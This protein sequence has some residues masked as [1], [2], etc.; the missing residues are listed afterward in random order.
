MFYNIKN[1]MVFI[2]RIAILFLFILIISCNQN[3]NKPNP[4]IPPRFVYE[5]K[6]VKEGELYFLNK[7]DTLKK[8]NI[9]IAEKSEEREQGL[10]YRK[11][12]D[13]SNGMLFIFE[14]SEPQNFWMKNTIIPLDIIYINENKEIVTIQ[15]NTVPFSEESIPSYKNAMF[16]VEVNAGFCGKFRIKEGTYISFNKI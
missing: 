12:M 3:Q 5:P 7:K 2:N 8:I 14:K 6:F 9:E 1:M 11:S 15:E 16:V 13:E 4:N 10:M